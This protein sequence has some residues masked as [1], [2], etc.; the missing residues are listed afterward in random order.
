MRY[1][2]ETIFLSNCKGLRLYKYYT[3]ILVTIRLAGF[4]GQPSRKALKEELR[5]DHVDELAVFL[6]IKATK[7]EV[8]IASIKLS[9]GH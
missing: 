1:I 5:S 7:D 8:R 9:A 6:N 2:K 3:A 4:Y